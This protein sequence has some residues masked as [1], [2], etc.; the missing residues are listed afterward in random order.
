[1]ERGGQY[2]RRAEKKYLRKAF[3]LESVLDLSETDGH[4]GA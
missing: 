1:M 3:E 4:I 2:A